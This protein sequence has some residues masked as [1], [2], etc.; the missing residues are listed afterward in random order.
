MRKF[1]YILCLFFLTGACESV[2]DLEPKNNVTFDHYFR[3]ERDLEA[4]VAQMHGELRT[5]MAFVTYQD[6]IGLNVDYVKGGNNMEKVRRL[7]PTVIASRFYQQNWKSYY[8]VLSIADLFFD[9]YQKAEGVMPARINFYTGQCYFV[10]AVCYMKLAQMWGEAVITKGSTY[11]DKYPKSPAI[12]VV[13]TA[14]ASAEKAY[15]LLPKYSEIKNS[16]N[17]VLLSKQYGCKGS[18]AGLLVHLYTWKGTVLGDKNALGEAV[19][20]A[21]KL[22]NPE[23]SAETGEYKLA[24][25]PEDVCVTEMKRRGSESIFELEISYT[26]NENYAPFIPGYNLVGWPVKRTV[27]AADIIDNTYGIYTGT[28]NDMY[29]QQDS[30]RTAYF[31]EPDVAGRNSADLAYLYKWRYVLYRASPTGE[32]SFINFD[33]NRVLIRLADIY[34]LRAEC[35]AKSGDLPGAK[36][37][38]NVIRQRAGATEYPAAINDEN[39]PSGLVRAIF[40]EREREL[41]FEGNRYYDVVRNYYYDR[42]YLKEFAENF[43]ELTENDVKNGALYLPVPETAFNYNDLMIQNVYWLSKLQ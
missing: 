3:N 24:A 16:N 28:V 17:K 20:W 1:F 41:L 23:N 42:S 40:K 31:Y 5:A 7:D 34:L 26:D 8:D 30:R 12:A 22:L 11:V 36:E 33:A 27:E 43:P 35:K 32:A 13:D 2:L 25:T 10:R 19:K 29:E 39:T 9:N 38:L 6:H 14:I 18:V 4:V 21:D 15:R 37:D